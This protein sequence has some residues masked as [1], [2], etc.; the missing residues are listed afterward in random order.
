MTQ[1]FK[2]LMRCHADSNA[3]VYLGLASC[4]AS[5]AFIQSSLESELYRPGYPGWI[6]NLIIK[7]IYLYLYCSRQSDIIA[8][9]YRQSVTILKWVQ[10][11]RHGY[12]V[13]VLNRPVNLSTCY[14]NDVKYLLFIRISS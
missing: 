12:R 13:T 11:P 1:C 8:I 9:T 14:H 3:S 5:Q 6:R 10:K 7:G 4:I 2:H